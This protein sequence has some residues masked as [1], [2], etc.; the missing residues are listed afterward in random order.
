MGADTPSIGARSC[1]VLIVEQSRSLARIYKGYLG[2]LVPGPATIQIAR[3]GREALDTA[4]ACSPDL[5]I[6]D[7]GIEDIRGSD[8]VATLRRLLPH[9]AIFAVAVQRSLD[10]AVDAMRAGATDVL[11]KPLDR[12]KFRAAIHEMPTIESPAHTSP[13]DI[14]SAE[15]VPDTGTTDGFIGVSAAMQIIYKTIAVAAPSDATVFI[16]GESG[17][18]KELYAQAIHR[19]SRRADNAL[20][21]LNCSAI[22][23]DLIESEIFGHV[24]GAFTGATSNRDGAAILADGGTLFLDEICEMNLDLQTKLLR[25][26]QTSTVQKVGDS[27]TRKVDVRF[28][29]ATNRNLLDEVAAGR[30]REDL[31]YRLHVIP[32]HMPP[33][34]ER[35]GDVLLLASAF[36]QQ[37][38]HREGKSFSGFDA[39]TSSVLEAYSWPGNVRE[40]ENL[41]QNIVVMN[42]G[43]EVSEEMLPLA[44]SRTV[45]QNRP[46]TA[47]PPMSRP[48]P[49]VVNMPDRQQKTETHHRERANF[50]VQQSQIKPLW[51]EER[52][53]IEQAI[54]VCEG[55]MVLAAALL[56]VSPSTLY[57][58][59]KSWAKDQ[60]G[61]TALI[62]V[63]R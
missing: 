31:Y 43:S 45:G 37:F 48:V 14:E 40:L 13:V 61:P 23:R 34:R 55:N 4:E 6:L 53:A 51:L 19:R 17:T 63:A 27:R 38:A 57:R 10:L 9:A 20:I 21:S 42:P 22:P 46:S 25:F 3:T 18:G 2:A 56:E 49:F 30:F 29:C 35:E 39:S 44:L 16:T 12:D 5:I 8:L 60:P 59:R 52:N 28:L 1:V 33:L 41:V 50:A 26:I 47:L 15:A 24:R 62:A 58:K 7:M 54:R 32:V 36:L 11:I